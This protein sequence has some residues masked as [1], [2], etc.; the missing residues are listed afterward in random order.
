MRP[1]N[2]FLR[3]M[4]FELVQKVK[5]DARLRGLNL[6]EWVAE[7]MREKLE[8]VKRGKKNG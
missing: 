7:A 5:A 2:F 6:P 3:G 4:P 1:V 8:K